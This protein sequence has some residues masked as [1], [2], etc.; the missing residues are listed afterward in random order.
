MKRSVD[1][2]AMIVGLLLALAGCASIVSTDFDGS[3]AFATYKTWAFAD[4]DSKDDK[5]GN[6]LSLDGTRVKSAVERE[7]TSESLQEVSAQK[8]D[9][10]VNYRFEDAEKLESQG[11]NYGFGF[12]SGNFGFGL[13]TPP[14]VRKIKEGKLVVELVDRDS[15]RVVW[16]G[17][18]RRYL[19]EGQSPES[20][21]ELIDEV[22]HAMF[23]KYPPI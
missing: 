15:Q 12:G 1:M 13:S 22:V 16:S 11:F 2:R 21:R 10:L 3:V 17:V 8:A 19:S 9:L 7:L 6:Y 5:T 18:S 14:Q 23:E 20:R 4:H